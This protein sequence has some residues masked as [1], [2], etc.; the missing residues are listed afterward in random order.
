MRQASASF[1][2]RYPILR[3]RDLF[4][5][6]DAAADERRRLVRMVA[7][8][9]HASHFAAIG[10]PLDELFAAELDDAGWGAATN[11]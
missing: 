1:D 9:K 7:E 4:E 3:L 2:G 8:F 10:L 5:L 11:G 6:I